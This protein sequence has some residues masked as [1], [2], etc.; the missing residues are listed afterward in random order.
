VGV[1]FL[2]QPLARLDVVDPGFRDPMRGRTAV[3]LAVKSPSNTAAL[4]KVTGRSA[5]AWRTKRTLEDFPAAV[6][7]DPHGHCLRI[8]QV[9]ACHTGQSL[10]SRK[11]AVLYQRM[12]LQAKV[13]AVEVI[14]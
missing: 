6:V 13:V 12:R 8:A 9:N 4:E 11:P 14:R 5:G 1:R 3:P 2:L 7:H 10:P